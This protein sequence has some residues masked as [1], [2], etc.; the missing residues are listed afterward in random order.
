[1]TFLE[2]VKYH[3]EDILTVIY[4]FSA[5]MG[6]KMKEPDHRFDISCFF[7]HVLFEFFTNGSEGC[8]FETKL[9]VGFDMTYGGERISI[10]IQKEIFP[11]PY[12][13]NP[14]KNTKPKDLVMKNNLGKGNN[15]IA[16]DYLFAVE[17]AEPDSPR[18]RFGVADLKTIKKNIRPNGTDQIK[19]RI[20]DNEWLFL[21][22]FTDIPPNEFIDP[23]I[24]DNVYSSGRNETFSNMAALYNKVKR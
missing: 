4:Q 6:S 8:Q 14:Q 13:S 3:H 18:I 23:K 2:F 21:S 19:T 16:C 1:M 7:Q 12:K 17:R 9:A 15:N 20:P 24:V 10:K 11:H 22:D 5:T